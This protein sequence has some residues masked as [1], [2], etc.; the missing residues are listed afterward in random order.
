MGK[1]FEGYRAMKITL[2]DSVKVK[3]SPYGW[4]CLAEYNIRIN[5]EFAHKRI[6]LNAMPH[7][8]T[9]GYWRTQLWNLFEIFGEFT[10]LGNES[11]AEEIV[12][13]KEDKA[14]I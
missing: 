10:G 1:E 6:T 12:I 13:E 7:N 4:K 11:W 5:K 9:G 3:L 14:T 8:L 2:N